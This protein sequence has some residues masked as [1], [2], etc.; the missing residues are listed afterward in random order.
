MGTILYAEDNSEI[1]KSYKE[2]F[3]RAFPDYNILVVKSGNALEK[4]L[5]KGIKDVKVVI[6]DN[7]I[8]PGP[9]GSKIIV[10]YSQKRGFE[11]IPF[12]LH[13]MGDRSTG[14]FLVRKYNN[15]FYRPKPIDFRNFEKFIKRVL[16]SPTLSSQ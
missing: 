16:N 10:N 11:Q 8:P 1:R 7:D 12:I 4:K 2:F 15:V 9:K 5:S 14:E 6:T 3:Q 13:Y